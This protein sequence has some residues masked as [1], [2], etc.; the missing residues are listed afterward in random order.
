MHANSK[1]IE[2]QNISNNSYNELFNYLDFRG[3][4]KKAEYQELLKPQLTG[5]Y[6][7]GYTKL[8]TSYLGRDKCWFINSGMIIG[9]QAEGHKDGA[10]SIFKA[11]TP[12]KD[13]SFT[14]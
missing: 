3:S 11:G 13:S 7:R 14:Y 5:R 2:K 4:Q 1:L 12:Q 9:L 8:H 6:S 10:L